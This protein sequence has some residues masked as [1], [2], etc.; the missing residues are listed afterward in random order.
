MNKPGKRRP[1]RFWYLVT[2]C[3]TLFFQL[4]PC[5]NAVNVE[6]TEQAAAGYGDNIWKLVFI[7]FSK[8]LK[9][10]DEEKR[11]RTKLQ[12]MLRNES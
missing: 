5:M 10:I 9:S 1:K 12:S 6:K 2:V 3:Q 4:T 7:D 11:K 8:E